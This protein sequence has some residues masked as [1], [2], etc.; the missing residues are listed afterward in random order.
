MAGAR[1]AA[2][3]KGGGVLVLVELQS[4]DIS[5]PNPY[6]RQRKSGEIG[7]MALLYV[8]E[9]AHL[10]QIGTMKGGMVSE[11]GVDQAPIN[12]AGAGAASVAF[13]ATTKYIR[14][15]SDTTCFIVFGAAPQV[16]S[17]QNA[18]LPANIIE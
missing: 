6:H 9:Y 18:L 5:A 4:L 1:F 8:K 12:F 17:N 2:I 7:A 3:R 13:A 16:A 10:P 15:V 11:P 14:V